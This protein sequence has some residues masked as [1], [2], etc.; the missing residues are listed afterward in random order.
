MAQLKRGI[1]EVRTAEAEEVARKGFAP[2][3]QHHRRCLRKRFENLSK[4]QW[5][6]LQGLMCY[7]LKTVPAYLLKESFPL[8]GQSKSYHP[9]IV[10][11]TSASS[12]PWLRPGT[13]VIAAKGNHYPD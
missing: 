3:L 12:P 2:L 13:E 1:D 4:R 10:P 7:R 9:S 6:R 5:A 8:P 11:R